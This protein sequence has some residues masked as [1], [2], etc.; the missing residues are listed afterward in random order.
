MPPSKGPS[1]RHSSCTMGFYRVTHSI[2]ALARRTEQE[3]ADAG[4]P[5]AHV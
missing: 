4:C 3:I 2:P 5:S 1:P